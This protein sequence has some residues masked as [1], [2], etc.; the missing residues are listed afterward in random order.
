MV[1]LAAV[2][3]GPGHVAGLGRQRE[4]DVGGQRMRDRP[5]V[6]RRLAGLRVPGRRRRGRRGVAGMARAEEAEADDAEYR[7]NA[8]RQHH[9]PVS[10]P[11]L[12]QLDR[13]E[14]LE[15][16]GGG[17]RLRRR[18]GRVVLPDQFF[19][20][21]PD[22][23]GDAPDVP[24]RVEVTA[25]GRVVP[26]LDPAD[27]RLPDARPL[28][29]LRDGETGLTARARQ[30]VTDAHAT[31]PSIMLHPC[32]G[33]GPRRPR[34]PDVGF[35]RIPSMGPVT[36]CRHLVTLRREPARIRSGTSVRRH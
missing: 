23:A 20:V 33:P 12:S 19:R 18:L 11:P 24:A 30:G 6:R 2:S 28:A 35:P 8:D 14:R 27:D 7:D 36:Q 17:D 9:A 29:N 10:A 13:R 5:G 22:R 16:I 31:P 4:P 15:H 1:P 34:L 32:P 21:K 26:P 3:L 25:A